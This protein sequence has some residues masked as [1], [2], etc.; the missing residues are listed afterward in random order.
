MKSY[1][2]EA[3]AYD[4]A[5]YCCGCLPDGVTEESEEASP[6]FADSEWDCYPVCDHCGCTHDYVGLTSYGQA[7]EALREAIEQHKNGEYSGFS[8]T[9][10]SEYPPDDYEGEWL[11]VN[12]RGNCTL[13]VRDI[14]GNDKEIASCV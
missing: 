10:E 2:Y 13:Y 5:V 11:H 8:S 1:D 7:R 6:I 12:E 3:V 14:N 4:G 9:R